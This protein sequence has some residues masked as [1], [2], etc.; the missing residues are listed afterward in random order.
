MWR[1]RDVGQ[2]KPVLK[3]F[4]SDLTGTLSQIKNELGPT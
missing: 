4:K 3:T 1:R 2:M